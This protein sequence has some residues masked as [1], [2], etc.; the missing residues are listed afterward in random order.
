[1]LYGFFFGM[2]VVTDF[3]HVPIL[4]VILYAGIL[5]VAV[6]SYLY[7]VLKNSVLFVFKNSIIYT[8]ADP[9]CSSVF[10]ACKGCLRNYKSMFSVPILNK[11]I[12]TIINQIASAVAE[13]SSDNIL[14][15]YVD[16]LNDNFVFKCGKKMLAK[17]FDYFDECVLAYSYKHPENSLSESSLRAIVIFIKRLPALLA[18]ATA[19]S[20]FCLFSDIL[21][22]IIGYLI[23]FKL[24]GVSIS[25]IVLTYILL[26][27]IRFVLDDAIL[28]QLLMGSL[29]K[30]FIEF[31]F[32]EAEDNQ[33]LEELK[34]NISGVN[35]LMSE[36]F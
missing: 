22:W 11:L 20:A 30:T 31:E 4:A 9:N 33:L 8:Y 27:A 6:F 12:R 10:E 19:I 14:Y 21:L 34:E 15:K 36:T 29:I 35:D 26:C 5:G 18:K 28:H 16:G 23:A 2:R 17:T 24:F 7:G 32:S 1:M 13:Q 25:V 3:L